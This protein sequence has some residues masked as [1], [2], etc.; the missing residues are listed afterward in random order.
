M[1]WSLARWLVDRIH[2]LPVLLRSDLR[3]FLT[4]LTGEEEVQR[5]TNRRDGSQFSDFT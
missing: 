4:D 2:R 5:G 1:S 3:A